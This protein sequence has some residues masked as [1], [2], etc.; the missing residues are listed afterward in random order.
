MKVYL[1]I[2]FETDPATAGGSSTATSTIG[3]DESY[4]GLDT[5]GFGDI[6]IGTQKLVTLTNG[7]GA[8]NVGS[9]NPSNAD[10]SQWVIRPSAGMS[11]AAAFGTP[12]GADQNR[13]NYLSPSIAGF[14]FAA[15][16]TPST[17]ESDA[18][19]LVGGTAGTEV[20]I[21]DA[22]LM[23]G[24]N[25]AG[26]ATRAAVGYINTRGAAANS[27]DG[28]QVGA[29]IK[30][31]DFT[32]GGFYAHIWN[33]GANEGASATAAGT[34]SQNIDSFSAGLVYNPGPYRVGV[35]TTQTWHDGTRTV[36]GQDTAKLYKLGA[37]YTLGPG[38]ELTGDLFHMTW[39]DEQSVA[40]FSNKGWGLVGGIAVTF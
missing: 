5:N 6:R 7:V 14:R 23:Y 1:Q 21:V 8:P 9:L 12:S 18:Q 34:G 26:F 25:V 36:A 24:F 20:Q 2:E 33:A 37:G 29:D 19:P 28:V 4:L 31:A 11:I 35:R 16:Y 10:T 39:E 17:T 22:S 40:A 32:L 13:I 27:S 15:G 38:V 3:L 30:I